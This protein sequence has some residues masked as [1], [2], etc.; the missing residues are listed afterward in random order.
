MVLAAEVQRSETELD[1]GVS[2][3][4][5]RSRSTG[6][7]FPGA[8]AVIVIVVGV[9][10]GDGDGALLAVVDT[11]AAPVVASTMTEGVGVRV[12]GVEAGVGSWCW[13]CGTD[14][15]GAGAG[16]G[17]DILRQ[18][19]GTQQQNAYACINN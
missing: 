19:V 5:G 1:G 16:A 6:L 14:D 15:I 8:S 2:G 17:E 3:S 9:A 4:G 10:V 11:E 12:G 7:V 13:T 18:A